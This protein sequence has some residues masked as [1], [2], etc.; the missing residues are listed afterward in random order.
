MKYNNQENILSSHF[1]YNIN[2][3]KNTSNQQ[4]FCEHNKI[5]TSQPS[6]DENFSEDKAME[7]NENEKF[8][9]KILF[10]I[11]EED[12]KGEAE[13]KTFFD[14]DANVQDYVIMEF[15]EDIFKIVGKTEE[16]EQEGNI[17]VQYHI[18]KG[19]KIKGKIQFKINLISYYVSL[20]KH[21]VF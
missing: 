18:N 9:P 16:S 4:V 14:D 7:I 19:K 15:V 13:L 10:E 8:D 5:K 20:C 12:M 1:K 17:S 11:K 21:Q 2:N 6:E 3:C